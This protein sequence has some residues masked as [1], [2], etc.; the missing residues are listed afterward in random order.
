MAAV[1]EAG[2]FILSPGTVDQAV[3]A[4][5]VDWLI[6]VEHCINGLGIKNLFATEVSVSVLQ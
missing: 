4:L 6:F 3:I 2:L 5:E 1:R